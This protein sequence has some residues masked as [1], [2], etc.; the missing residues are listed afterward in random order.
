MK[1][2]ASWKPSKFE[3]HGES[4]RASRDPKQVRVS[5][6]LVADIQARVYS[7]V[8][9]R[10]ARG[11]LL[12]LGCGAVPLYECYRKQV[13][14]VTC[15]DWSQSGHLQRHID[16]VHDLNEP[17][18]FE[19][20]NFD[21]LLVTDVLEHILHPERLWDEMARVLRPEGHLILAVPFLYWIHEEPYD[22]HR[23]TEHKLRDFCTSRQLEPVE[24][25]AYGGVAE[26]LAD[27]LAKTL[28]GAPWLCAAFVSAAS[29]A[30]R[31]SRSDTASRNGAQLFP[32]GYVLVAQKPAA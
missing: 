28:R 3:R 24:L 29:L 7:R 26:V 8:V 1:D 4:Y 11:A 32:L 21:T 20:A 31:L 16:V 17:L 10:Y 12:D 15:L 23:F 5:S 2:A 25:Q 30:C 27:L 22:Y 9:R 14:G 13:S 18:P 6:R 19:D